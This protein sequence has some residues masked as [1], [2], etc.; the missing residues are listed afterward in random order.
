MPPTVFHGRVHFFFGNLSTSSKSEVGAKRGSETLHTEA[1][2]E[3]MGSETLRPN[4]EIPNSG[5]LP[6]KKSGILLVFPWPHLIL[7]STFLR[8]GV[9]KICVFSQAPAKSLK[10]EICGCYF[11]PTFETLLYFF[12]K[13]KMASGKSVRV[14]VTVKSSYLGH[15]NS[16]SQ[17][18]FWFFWFWTK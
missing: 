11:S 5:W 17:E 6:S 16:L 12:A 10:F 8:N 7:R 4:F 3:K 13:I 18:F 2:S 15:F 9:R 1:V 14:N